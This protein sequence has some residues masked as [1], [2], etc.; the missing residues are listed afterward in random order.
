ACDRD[1]KSRSQQL[2][3]RGNHSGGEC[4]R[5]ALTRDI[6]RMLRL[7]WIVAA[8]IV[9]AAMM[10][11]SAGGQDSAVRAQASK[12]V[13][14]I[15]S[16]RGVIFY[17]LWGI[18][19]FAEKYGIRTEMIPIMT[20][21]DQQRALQTGGADVATQGYVN[22]A[23]M[24]EQNVTNVKIVSGLY[25]GGQNLI[26]RKGVELKSW[27]ELEGKKIGRAPGTF[28]QVLFILAAEANNVAV[29]QINLVNVTAARTP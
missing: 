24:A 13:V 12:K 22:P 4:A 17:P 23:I 18:E 15:A 5:I 28:A 21:A 26:M 29:S 1:R 19:P 27:K 25:L 2:A 3:I 20:N 16:A 7:R 11:M 10:L 9:P 14:R 6:E 8:A